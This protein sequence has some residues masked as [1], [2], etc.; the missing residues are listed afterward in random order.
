MDDVGIEKA[1]LYSTEGLAFGKVITREF[2]VDSARAYNDW[3]YDAYLRQ[4]PRFHCLGLIP[5]QEP[6][7]A[8]RELRRIVTKGFCGAL[9]PSTGFKGHLGDR[10][11]WPIYDEAN[12]LECCI[13]IHGGAHEGLGLDW[14]TPYAP[15]NALGHP[16]G[17][18]VAFAGIIFNGILDK[19]PMVRFGFMEGG[20]S[21][22][23]MCMERFERSR[24]THIQYD[25][26]QN[27]IQLAKDEPV[28]DYIRKH[29]AAKRIFVGCEGSE[30]TMPHVLS[31]V[32]SNPFVFS[33]DF[34]HEVNNE[35]SKQE[36]E[37]IVRHKS[38]DE[39]DKEAVLFKNAERFYGLQP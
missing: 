8:V 1:V 38:L 39:E 25:P 7:E 11:Y 13:S 33:S 15:I 9:I 27:Y 6:S 24:E 12:R 10:I 19:L 4:S 23:Q 14:L 20:V 3:L 28:S 35:S 31:Y 26:N 34:P 18:M 16:F 29:I 2:A 36:I 17:V 22:I 5:L 30:P 21:W 37:A 32:G